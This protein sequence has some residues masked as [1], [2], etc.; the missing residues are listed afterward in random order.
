MVSCEVMQFER[1]KITT[2]GCFMVGSLKQQKGTS[3]QSN[4]IRVLVS[5]FDL[6]MFA[7]LEKS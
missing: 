7:A 5:R 2:K 1:S 3:C 4:P 6:K